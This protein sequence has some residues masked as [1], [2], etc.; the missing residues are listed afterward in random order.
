MDIKELLKEAT[1]DTLSDENLEKIVE[2]V[3]NKAQELVDAHENKAELQV[4]SALVKQDAEYA[5][6]LKTFL[7]KVDEDHTKKLKTLIECMDRKHTAGL[8]MVLEKCK[9]RYINESKEFKENLVNKVDKFFDIVTENQIPQKELE[10]AV[11]NTRARKLVEEIGRIIGMDKVNQNELVREGIMDAKSQ[12]NTLKEQVE[13]LEKERKNI[14]VEKTNI[15]RERLLE[16]KTQGLPKVKKDYIKSVLG[17]RPIEFINENFDYTLE[18]FDK[19]D[20]KKTEVIK[21]EAINESKTYKESVDRP[22]KVV[23]ERTQPVEHADQYMEG[24]EGW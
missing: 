3:D 19:D 10:E 11:E 17:K 24:L 1:K 12:I 20:E 2:A 16:E 14:L 9:T 4:E 8:R 22:K 15:E 13:T 21:E 18:L 6:K 23:E 5:E 7:E